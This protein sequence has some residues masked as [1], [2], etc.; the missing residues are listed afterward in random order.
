MQSARTSPLAA[1]TG[2]LAGAG[3]WMLV[4][5]FTC[6]ARLAGRGPCARRAGGKPQRTG[7][8]RA[9]LDIEPPFFPRH[10]VK[11]RTWLL[12]A[13][14]RNFTFGTILRARNEFQA[15]SYN[16]W[17]M[18]LLEGATSRVLAKIPAI[19]VGTHSTASGLCSRLFTFAP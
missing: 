5:A 12:R 18:P 17:L 3:R 19:R 9:Y 2:I 8:A 10:Y 16:C 4:R 7:R 15:L 13:C 14:G 6:A 11:K 1:L